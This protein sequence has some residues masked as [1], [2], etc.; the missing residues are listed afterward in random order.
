MDYR[1]NVLVEGESLVCLI[2][3]APA[4]NASD[5][6]KLAT[7]RHSQLTPTGRH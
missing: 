1:L 3:V 6:K 5:L 7:V 4:D 2:R